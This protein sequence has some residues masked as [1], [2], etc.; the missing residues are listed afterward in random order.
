MTWKAGVSHKRGRALGS[1]V[2]SY[3]DLCVGL[4]YATSMAE[5]MMLLEGLLTEEGGSKSR[6][7]K[8][9]IQQTEALLWLCCRCSAI[10]TLPNRALWRF[11]I[12]LS[13]RTP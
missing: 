12:S 6:R 7:K 9:R 8:L 1:L 13:C 5:S 2:S 10:P 11:E 3:V 4:K